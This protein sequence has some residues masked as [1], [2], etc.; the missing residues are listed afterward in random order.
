MTENEKTF[1]G[2]ERF[3]R[4]TFT[5]SSILAFAKYDSICS[6]LLVMFHNGTEYEYVG[7]D[8]Q[9]WE[10]FITATSAGSYF[11]T[12]IRKYKHQRLK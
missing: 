2:T 6:L 8:Q 1:L 4:H 9:T 10:E 5:G 7:V 3:Y 12:V 11:N